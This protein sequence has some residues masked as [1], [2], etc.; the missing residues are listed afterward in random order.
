MNDYCA[1]EGG[2]AVKERIHL[3]DLDPMDLTG[4]PYIAGPPGTRAICYGEPLTGPQGCNEPAF[5]DW[6]EWAKG[7]ELI[8]PDDL[9]ILSRGQQHALRF[10][11]TF[12]EYKD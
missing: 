7:V 4:I 6:V 11:K 12:T 10:L 1:P 9:S 2:V 8:V 3:I 5:D